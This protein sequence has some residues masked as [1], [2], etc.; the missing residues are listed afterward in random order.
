MKPRLIV[1]PR[2]SPLGRSQLVNG[3]K[4]ENPQIGTTFAHTKTVALLIGEMIIT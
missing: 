1:Q 3:S 4:G 2:R